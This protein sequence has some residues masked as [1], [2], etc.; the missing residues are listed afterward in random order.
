MNLDLEGNTI[1][2]T[3]AAKGIGLAIARR[4]AD[5][6]A[7]VSGWDLDPGPDAADPAF[8]HFVRVDVTDEESVAE[9]FSQ[10]LAAL[11]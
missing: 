9:G 2:V 7:K 8:A 1:V 6:G 3:G 10:S 11:G 4:F 5:L